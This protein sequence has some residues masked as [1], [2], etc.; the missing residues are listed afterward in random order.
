MLRL[1]PAGVL[2]RDRFG[3][4]T[5]QAR[6]VVLLAQLEALGL[7]RN[8]VS[9]GHL[10]LGLLREDHGLAAQALRSLGVSYSRLRAEH[11]TVTEVFARAPFPPGAGPCN[12]RSKRQLLWLTWRVKRVLFDHAPA[13]ARKLGHNYLG[14]EHLLLGLLHEDDA[15]AA[16]LARVGAPP[17]AIRRE[18][19]RLLGEQQPAPAE[20][21]VHRLHD[22]VAS[23]RALLRQHGI[24][25][26][27]GTAQ[28]GR[29]A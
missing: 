28:P 29:P 19:L 22:E 14:T 8:Y 18:V 21:L 16:D 17:P 27:G 25:S 4:F 15:T 6:A 11:A 26:D 2:R 7:G 23:L 3:A 12:P 10:L 13:E 24:E 9:T 1:L 5:D 20:D